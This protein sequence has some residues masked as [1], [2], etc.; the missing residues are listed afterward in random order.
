MMQ[1]DCLFLEKFERLPKLEPKSRAILLGFYYVLQCMVVVVVDVDFYVLMFL[2]FYIFLYFY[3]FMFIFLC[4][5]IFVCF[6]AK[7]AFWGVFRPQLRKKGSDPYSAWTKYVVCLHLYIPENLGSGGLLP[8][9][10]RGPVC[11]F[12]SVC[13]FVGHATMLGTESLHGAYMH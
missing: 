4:Y 12:L 5:F 11:L 7:S 2:Y 9:E 3:V 10:L 6:M 8:A 1:G 13:L